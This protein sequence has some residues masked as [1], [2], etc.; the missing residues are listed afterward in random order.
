[1]RHVR[2]SAWTLS[3]ACDRTGKSADDA[4]DGDRRELIHQ[5]QAISHI[6]SIIEA[7]CEK[8]AN[9]LVFFRNTSEA[10]KLCSVLEIATSVSLV[11]ESVIYY[12]LSRYLVEV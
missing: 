4:V 7:E 8:R 6:G 9:E 2:D 3:S 1:M 5:A 10:L 12:S 11:A